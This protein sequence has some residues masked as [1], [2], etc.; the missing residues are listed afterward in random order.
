M[1]RVKREPT[2]KLVCEHET[3]L[4]KILTVDGKRVRECTKCYS[5]LED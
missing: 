3:R 1:K 5:F 2:V 4:T